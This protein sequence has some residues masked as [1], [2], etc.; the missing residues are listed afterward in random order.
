MDSARPPTP[1]TNT[2]PP[3]KLG[4]LT[5][6]SL[7]SPSTN[8]T[9]TLPWNTAVTG[10]ETSSGRTTNR[11]PTRW[12]GPHGW[13]ILLDPVEAYDP[14][15]QADIPIGSPPLTNA[16]ARSVIR[17]RLTDGVDAIPADALAYLAAIP[18]CDTESMEM[19]WEES[20]HYGWGIGHPN[21][22]VGDTIRDLVSVDEIWASATAHRALYADQH[23]ATDLFIDILN[24]TPDGDKPLVVDRLSHLEGETG[25]CS[26]AT[27]TSRR[28]SIGTSGSSG[29]MQSSRRSGPASRQA[30]SSTTYRTTGRFPTSK[31]AGGEI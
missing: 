22:P 6:P 13:P 28:N 19:T 5:A 3:P 26:P 31:P 4:V 16:V 7:S 2:S 15:A 29:T 8:R 17:T 11:S 21:H 30:V 10:S 20:I 24:L 18:R 25:S 27:G 23:A 14:Q 1:S 9:S 12:I